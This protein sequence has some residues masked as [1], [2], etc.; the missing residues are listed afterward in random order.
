MIDYANF[1]D[2]EKNEY[3]IAYEA[4]CGLLKAGFNPDNA[5]DVLCSN[6][7][8]L[9]YLR[10]FLE[11]KI[12]RPI[13][14][15]SYND[16]ITVVNSDITDSNWWDKAKSRLTNE[17]GYW[18]RYSQ[19]LREVK[20]W[21]IND[22][23]NN[24][25]K[26]TDTLMNC[27]LNPALNVEGKRQG[28]VFGHVQSGKTSHFIGLINK[29]IDAG[30]NVIIVLSGIHND[31]RRQTQQRIDS[32]VLGNKTGTKISNEISQTGVGLISSTVS[33]YV[34]PVTTEDDDF[35]AGARHNPPFII[36]TKKN[37]SRLRKVRDYLLKHYRDNEN[38]TRLST[39]Y[40]LL[41]IDDEADQASL[42][43]NP[44]RDKKTKKLNEDFDP[45]KINQNI[46]EIL[47][48]FSVRSYVGYTATPF[49]NLFVPQDLE[50]EELGWDLFPRDFIATIPESPLYIGAKK[51]FGLREEKGI[52]KIDV[53]QQMPLC[54]IIPYVGKKDEVEYPDLKKALY[55]F[56]LTVACRN[57]RGQK[58]QPNSMLIHIDRHKDAHSEIQADVIEC[59]KTICSGISLNNS[60]ELNE[61]ATVWADMCQTTEV[62]RRDF[63]EYM[64]GIPDVEWDDVM[65]EVRRLTK[66]DMD[67]D[68]FKHGL[69]KILVIN[70]DTKGTDK[71]D[72]EN[73]KNKEYNVIVI[74]GDKLSRGLTLEGLS[75]SYFIRKAKMYDTLMQMGRWFGYRPGYA[76]L[77]RLFLTKEQLASY[78]KVT[79][80]TYDMIRQFR[81]LQEE[82]KKPIDIVLR[83]AADNKLLISGNNKLQTGV[84]ERGDYQNSA[85]Q[86]RVICITPESFEKNLA[87]VQNLLASC[88]EPIPASEYYKNKGR[89]KTGIHY[90][91]EHVSAEQIVSFFD[92]FQTANTA[93][94]VSSQAISRSIRD[95]IADDP[96]YISDW[97]VCMYSGNDEEMCKFAGLP[98][99]HCVSPGKISVK[100]RDLSDENLDLGITARGN[101][102]Y[103]DFTQKELDDKK[104]L[105]KEYREDDSAYGTE[106]EKEVVRRL[107]RS[108][109]K[110]LLVL[111]PFTLREVPGLNIAGS[112]KTPFGFLV[113][114]PAKTNEK[115]SSFQQYRY[116]EKLYP[117]I[118]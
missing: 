73:Y 115:P 39:E 27:L 16:A 69:I 99:V 63:S 7:P 79:V 53:M 72:Y 40:K 49:A 113:V 54:E 35:D 101:D 60:M 12:T 106:K 42:N 51:F 114:F 37:V 74:G 116:T 68:D 96:T 17:H 36:V 64:S 91:W 88:G 118:K 84:V 2:G 29:G 10:E 103:L 111:Y 66:I 93:R 15:T 33:P 43:T 71:L 25:D 76:D 58:N 30:Y 90:F 24:I 108:P 56:L 46:R 80:A 55:H 98:E 13:S 97:T 95:E 102:E 87:A 100:R 8:E 82:G 14:Y 20:D 45:S 28:L 23:Q 70:S 105:E 11:E 44:I 67:E 18:N 62:M 22:I 81:E 57:C 83:I 59:W 61:L 41:L 9:K 3:Y 50:D 48:L 31:L 107:I 47:E 94:I 65:S 117:E 1:S 110:G 77:C 26:P 104:K 4:C 6:R 75:V 109:E 86:T 34:T 78:R 19:Y 92:N 32:D 5:I 85:N 112:V 21:D 38:Q 89:R 52:S